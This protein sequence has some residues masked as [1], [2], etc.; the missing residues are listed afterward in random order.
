MLP[1]NPLMLSCKFISFCNKS[2]MFSISGNK[3][4][5]SEIVVKKLESF[6]F[7][8]CIPVHIVAH[9]KNLGQLDFSVSNIGLIMYCCI[10]LLSSSS[11]A[12]L[13]NK[14]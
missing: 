8:L 3:I 11:F 1:L 13:L 4:I 2:I 14:S 10:K 9:C 5:S 12:F 7:L 6:K